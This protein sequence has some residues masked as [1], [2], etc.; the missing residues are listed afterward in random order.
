MDIRPIHTEADYEW[1]LGE[2]APYFDS[3]PERGT[4][5]ADRFNV[6]AALIAAYEDK[7]WP[8]VA[9]DPVST[10]RE[11]MALRGFAQADL[12]TLLDSRSRA[13]EL[14]SRQR[15]ITMAQAWKLHTEWGIPAEAL[16]QPTVR[17]A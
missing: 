17:A 1:A 3:E 12:A 7:H 16:I 4:P 10:V 15:S 9:S 8:I 5:E 14:L 13:S 11:T 6:L 2:I